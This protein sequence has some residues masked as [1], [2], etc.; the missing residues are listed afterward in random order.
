MPASLSRP[1]WIALLALFAV[2]WFANID[3]R[4]LQHPDE[5]RY[6]EIGREMAA[7]GDWVT[8]RLNGLKYFEKPALQYWLTA[9]SIDALGA[10]EGAARI[11][12]AVAGWLA[13]FAVGYAGRRIAGPATGAYAF[14]VLAGCFWWFGNA[15]FVTLDGLLSSWLALALAAFL[16]AQANDAT[17]RA[18]FVGM[19]VAWAAIAAATLTK[20]L[21]ALVIPGGALA[22]YSLVTRDFALWKRLH[23]VTGM[24]LMLVVAAPW[25]IVVAQKNPEFARFFFIHEHFER[26]LTTGHRRPGAWWYFV[27]V[28]GVGLLPWLGVWA[29]TARSTWRDAAPVANGFSWQR[30]CFVWAGFVFVFF[31]LSG[32]KLPSYILPM[33]PALALPIAWQLD[34]LPVATLYRL[35]LP[36]AIIT[37]VLWLGVMAGFGVL[38]ERLADARTPQAVYLE[39]APSIKAAFAV[40]TLGGMVALF[41]FRRS[42]DTAKMWGIASIALTAIVGL[43]CGFA[44]SDAF[45]ATRSAADIA[46]TLKAETNPRYD[47]AAPVFQVRMYDQTLPFYL[48]RTTTLVDYR[49]ELALGLDAEPERGIAQMPDW[50][51][52]WQALPQGYALMSAATL[53]EIEH[54]NV[55]LRVVARDPRRVLV[56][57][58]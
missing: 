51:G 18:Q 11:V 3:G 36:L 35:S 47:A 54:A 23:I 52:R 24:L 40:W 55:P 28:F 37:A 14:L 58:R 2:A 21:I 38:A 25:F 32:S 29:W 39:A 4:K 48:Q 34:R 31:S 16:V 9:A 27:P 13:L 30:F 53:A 41:L 15:H 56:A 7:T 50:I 8:P 26:F 20:G 12:P 22:L 44:A 17:R 33:F 5:G 1:A 57:R 45:R 42:G 19:H 6:A 43:Q 10:R 49:D 46:A